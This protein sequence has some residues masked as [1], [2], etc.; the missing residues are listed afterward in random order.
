[1]GGIA[2]WL[3][4][5]APLGFVLAMSFGQGRMSQGTLQLI[6]WG[7]AVAMGLSLST[8][9]LAYSEVVIAQAFF[10]AAAGFAGLSL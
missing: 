1:G 4:T 6:Y 9:F 2:K 10:T 7:F 5:F 8:I 3:I